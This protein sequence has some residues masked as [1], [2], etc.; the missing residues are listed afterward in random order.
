MKSAEFKKSMLRSMHRGCVSYKNCDTLFEC[1][2]CLKM[3]Q[4]IIG[5][6]MLVKKCYTMDYRLIE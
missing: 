1:L 2:K 6:I 5:P 3:M 4:S